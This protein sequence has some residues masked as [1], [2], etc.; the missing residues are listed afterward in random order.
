VLR[1]ARPL[2]GTYVEVAALAA[3]P[4]VEWR[5]V[6]AALDAVAEV[7]RLMSF[8]E[9]TSDVA[10]LNRRAAAGPVEIDPRTHAVL[11]RARDFSRWSAGSFDCT[12]GGRL[13]ALGLL[14]RS[15]RSALRGAGCW[16]D[17][18]L[19]PGSRV[20]FRRPLA[21]D[22]GGI[23]KG[24]AV[25]RAVDA[26]ARAGAAAGCV[27]AGG[28]LRVLGDRAWPV[29]VRDPDCPGARVP[30]APL[31]SGALATTS[32]AFSPDGGGRVVEPRTGRRRAAPQSVSIFA[33]RC[34]DADA[35]TKVVWL[36]PEPPLALLRRLRARALVL[37]SRSARSA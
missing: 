13:A 21:V 10:R 36:S 4:E 30:L 5:A 19:L 29:A 11:R 37:R 8:H 32:G 26:L 12:V 17:V 33:A 9:D 7:H 35:L 34:I 15:R 25:D 24:Y 20:R 6:A 1:R 22:L 31:R 27:N 16:R 18:E 23:A 14:P 2:L 3:S 28:D